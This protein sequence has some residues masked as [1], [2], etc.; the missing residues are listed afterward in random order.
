VC[1]LL[2]SHC[3]VS[4]TCGDL[5]MSRLPRRGL[6]VQ[7]PLMQCLTLYSRNCTVDTVQLPL[8]C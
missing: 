4:A 7:S 5:S 1:E 8:Y 2:R 3:Y 6:L